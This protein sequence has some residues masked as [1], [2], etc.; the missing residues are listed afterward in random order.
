M[1]RHYRS[2][3]ARRQNLRLGAVVPGPAR[4][5][6]LANEAANVTDKAFFSRPRSGE[7]P[8]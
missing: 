4:E 2:D 5:L 7:A 6:T 1:A 3:L 8:G